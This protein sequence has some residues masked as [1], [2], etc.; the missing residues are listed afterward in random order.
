MIQFIWF[1]KV[2]YMT[3]AVIQQSFQLFLGLGFIFIAGIISGHK[4][5]RNNPV[6]PVKWDRISI[7]CHVAAYPR[8]L[9]LINRHYVGINQTSRLLF[10][11]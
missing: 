7:C 1:H 2:N 8:I 4:F 9:I 5:P 11:L 6:T 3:N 10:L